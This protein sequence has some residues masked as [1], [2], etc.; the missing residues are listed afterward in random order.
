MSTAAAQPGSSWTA[1]LTTV[2]QAYS[3]NV[4]LDQAV[5]MVRERTG[6]RVL[7]AETRR[8]NGRSVHRIRVLSDDGRVRT[9]AVDAET[10]RIS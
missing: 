5:R 4:S 6:G 8:Q 9:Y 7:R 3:E 10:G 1:P 2:A